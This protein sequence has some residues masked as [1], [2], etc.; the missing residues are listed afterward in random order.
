MTSP[1]RRWTING[2]FL[3]QPMTGVQRYASGIVGA[4]DDALASG[5]PDAEG[6]E[7]TI[8]A[9]KGASAGGSLKRI[10]LRIAGGASG[11]LWEQAV[12]PLHTRGGLLSLCNAGPLA[13]RK[14]VLCIHDL[15]TRVCPESYSRAFRAYHRLAL[16]LIAAAAGTVT[17][18]SEAS[19]RQIVEHGLCGRDKIVVLPNGHEHALRWEPRHSAATRATASR[20]TIVMIASEAPHKNVGLVLGLAGALAEHGLR[21]ALVGGAAP[22]VFREAGSETTAGNVIRLGRLPDE[23]MAA[24]LKDSLCLAF[25]SITEGFGLP[26]LEAM[27]LGC[28][29]VSSDRASLPEICGD[30]ALYASPFEADAWLDRLLTLHRDPELRAAMIERGKARAAHYSWAKSAEGYLRAMRKADE[31]ARLPAGVAPARQPG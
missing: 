4:L 21:I 31:L 25:P 16:P 14:Q 5:H 17:T 2:R 9:P 12:L 11:H 7:V 10:G 27:A 15:N 6:L 13:V 23:E 29:V 1:V 26:P 22:G 30:A 8:V 28:P 20:E 24:L 3:T 19:A 18:V